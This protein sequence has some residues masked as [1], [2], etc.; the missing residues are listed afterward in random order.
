MTDNDNHVARCCENVTFPAR[1]HNF[2]TACFPK[3][4]NKTISHTT[5][6]NLSGLFKGTFHFLRQL[7]FSYLAHFADNIRRRS[8]VD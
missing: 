5:K 6:F 3:A 4:P 8:P 2:V 7:L 1:K